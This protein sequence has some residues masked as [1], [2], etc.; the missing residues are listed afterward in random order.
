[1]S[2]PS[3]SE[4]TNDD[5]NPQ[6]WPTHAIETWAP[7]FEEILLSGPK[8]FSSS[9]RPPK[10]ELK[11]LPSNLKYGFLGEDESYPVVISSKLTNLQES[12]LIEVL[13]SHKS[14]IG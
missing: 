12:K 9:D 2:E 4:S 6:S 10:P 7:K 5:L 11:P 3:K 14:T 8:P 1:M 13:K